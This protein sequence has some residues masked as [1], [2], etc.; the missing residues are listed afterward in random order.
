[1]VL[2]HM[3]IEKMLKNPKNLLPIF[4]TVLTKLDLELFLFQLRLQQI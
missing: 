3:W 2:K 1:M 4:L